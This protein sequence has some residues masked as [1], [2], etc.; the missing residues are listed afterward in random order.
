MS[1]ERLYLYDT[2][3]RD[4]AQTTG[5]DFSL[6]DKRRIAALLDA[7]GVDY[8]E[9][10]YP[11][12]NPLDTEFFAKKPK[13]AHAKFS[14]FGM[15]RRSGRSASN[16]P[17]VAALL[18][19]D[20]DA[21]CFVAKS[22]DYHVRVALGTTLED[23][24]AGVAQ[25][26]EFAVKRGRET[27]LDCEHFFDGYKANPAYALEVARTAYAAGARWIVLCD[28]NGGTLPHEVERIVARRRQAH[29]E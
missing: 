17:G 13:F 14:A 26:V 20:A 27:M 1:R 9:G 5:V 28:T 19:A 22:W 2:T 21:I 29:P 24:L 25:S 23:N 3:L 12:A 18:D 4:G 15:I 7:L 6:D 10:G 16:D 11:G 8:I